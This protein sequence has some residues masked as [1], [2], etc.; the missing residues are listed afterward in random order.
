MG[1]LDATRELAELCTIGEGDHVLDVGCGAGAT[2]AYL[3]QHYGCRVVG[4]DIST[5]MIDVARR[6][7]ARDCVADRVTFGVADARDLPFEGAM[8]DAVLCE[9]VLTFFG[10]K[11]RALREFVRVTNP[12]GHV[13]LNEETWLQTPPPADVLQ[14]AKRTWDIDAEIPTAE[15]WAGMLADAGLHDVV[16]RTH[17]FSARRESSQIW[18]YGLEDYV[19]MVYRT[20]RAYVRSPEFRR[21]MH[22]RRSV[23]QGVFEYLGYGIYGGRK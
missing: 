3:A 16:A 6:R 22:D 9:S 19:R 7:A 15:G 4:V 21:Y 20:L 10:D 18:R 14:F 23:P 13:G 17:K 12:S 5:A 11:P 2:A 8:F 1:G